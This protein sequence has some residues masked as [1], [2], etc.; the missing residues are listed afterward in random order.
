MI[1]F[2]ICDVL[3]RVFIKSVKFYF[4]YYGCDKCI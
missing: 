3:V 2:I 1:D 4:G